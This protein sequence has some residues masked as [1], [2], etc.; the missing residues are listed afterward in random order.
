MKGKGGSWR[1][2]LAILAVCLLAPSL[3]LVPFGALWLVQ[4]GYAL[5]WVGGACLLVL[6][7]FLV[8]VWVLRKLGVTPAS[9]K[10]HELPEDETASSW[11]AREIEAW[12]AVQE[13]AETSDLSALESVDSVLALG[14]RTI[15]AVAQ[16]L[17]P[18]RDDSVWQFTVPEAL[19]MMENVSARLKPVFADSI[20]LADRLTIGQVFQIYSWRGAVDTVQRAYDIWRMVRLLNPVTAATQELR[21]RLSKQLLDWS[22]EELARRIVGAYVKEVG[23][24]AID[25]YGGRLRVSPADIE[26]HVASEL[27]GDRAQ[28]RGERPVRILVGG[29]INAG[30][31]T[32]INA[33]AGEIKAASDVLPVDGGFA[34]HE[35][36]PAT[37]PAA[38]LVEAP[39]F[40]EADQDLKA[41][42][43]Q[44]LRSDLIL[45][46]VSAVR[47]DRE[48]DR[49]ALSAIR[50]AFA[51][52][53]DLRTPAIILAVTQVDKLRPYREWSPPYNLDAG[54]NEKAQSIKAALEAATA[55]LAVPPGDA[56][57][58]S[59]GPDS[60]PYNVDGLLALLL[61]EMPDA[62]RVKLVRAI[63]ESDRTFDWE[64]LRRQSINAGRLVI[65]VFKGNRQ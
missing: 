65:D 29:Q 61:A 18:E 13:I 49:R 48:A 9:V 27:A 16:V 8:Q 57:A 63:R 45:W 7:A 3:S 64:R 1:I 50:D 26:R 40:S 60:I 38:L 52:R 30:K 12:A 53:P 23:R 46:V 21:E 24:A 6:A 32:I 41:L 51:K 47:P 56:V 11:T 44:A 35:L 22:K 31:S 37:L 2:R 5:Y 62:A 55:D 10:A 42:I 25:L 39:G 54:S 4:N 34:V 36:K 19:T 17:H 43:E 33:L 20:P 58:V 14:Q 59:L 28:T 15:K